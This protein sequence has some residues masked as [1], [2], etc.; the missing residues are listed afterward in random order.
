[1][2]YPLA[3]E[4]TEKVKELFLNAL[5]RRPNSFFGQM[6]D[7]DATGQHGSIECGDAI[8]FYLK[9]K[10][11]PT[12]P[13]K[14][15]ILQARYE[16]FGCT[17]AI[18]SS[19]ALCAIIEANR[20]SPIDALKINNGHIVKFLGGIP[21]QKL[22]CSIMGAEVLKAAIYDWAL[23]RDVDLK[24]LG[25]S[26]K[27]FNDGEDDLCTC[28]SLSR[29]FI[30]SKIDQLNLKTVEQVEG[31]IKAGGSCGRCVDAPNGITHLLS[32]INSSKDKVVEVTLVP[33]NFEQKIRDSI[34]EL[35]KPIVRKHKGEIELVA[36]KE[37]L[38]YL[39]FE[40]ISKEHTFDQDK[41]KYTIQKFLQDTVYENTTI[42]DI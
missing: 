40:D 6:A 7:A 2:E 24:K 8:V 9:M 10:K 34:E 15:K 4:Y 42:V 11:H 27:D 29:G 35:I 36:I 12:D 28:F 16:T 5:Y 21:S 14:D 39:Q 31:A 3:W 32:E 17:S 30:S 1:M 13:L 33:K 18:A 41:M 38:V 26:E 37:N 23:K 19:E 22:H 20:F 25:L